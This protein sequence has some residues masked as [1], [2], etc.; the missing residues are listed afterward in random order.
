MHSAAFA[1]A[2]MCSPGT[3][4][5]SIG[6]ARTAVLGVTIA[7]GSPRT[8]PAQLVHLNDVRQNLLATCLATD[9]QG[10]MVGELGR[11]FRTDDGGKSWTRQDAATKRPFLSLACVDANSAWASTTQG[12]MYHTTDAGKQ[13][14]KVETGSNKHVFTLQFSTP[15]RGHGAGDYGHM[16]HTEDGGKTWT[17]NQVSTDTVLPESAL[18]TGVDPGDVNLYALSYGTPDLAWLVGEFGILLHTT[19]GG[20]T[21]KQQKTPVETTLFGVYF[22]DAQNGWV[23][24][25]DAT[26]LHTQDGGLTW[27]PQPVPVSARPLFDVRVSGQTGWIVGE[28]GTMLKSND[29]G[30]TWQLQELPIQLAARWIRS[31]FLTSSGKGLA[32][33]SEGL[34]FQLDGGKAERLAQSDRGGQS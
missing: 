32:V 19:D 10:W 18:D 1:R 17:K 6:L 16:I 34:V 28:S 2:R 21:W 23:V 15:Q 20:V 9:T 27:A 29:G 3:R 14:T 25:G 7:W 22:K 13:W 4:E 26:L 12:S 8:A 33:G 5:W 31:I 11:I 24:G 30:M